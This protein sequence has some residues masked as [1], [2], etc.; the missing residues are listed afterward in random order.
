VFGVL[1]AGLALVLATVLSRAPGQFEL[2]KQFSDP[3]LNQHT[4]IAAFDRLNVHDVFVFPRVVQ[5]VE[6]IDDPE[7]ARHALDRLARL[8]AEDPGS[9]AA[10]RES[11]VRDQF[12]RLL[13][14]L[15]RHE[16][17]NVRNAAFDFYSRFAPP[18]AVV[19][20]I[21]S[22]ARPIGKRTATAM[23]RYLDGLVLAEVDDQTL[24]KLLRNLAALVRAEEEPAL[25]EACAAKLDTLPPE[26][27]LDCLMRAF[28]P[29]AV[30]SAARDVL[31]PYLDRTTPERARA[32]GRYVEGRVVQ[33]VSRSEEGIDTTFELEF[34]IQALG[35]IGTLSGTDYD[36]GLDAIAFLLEHRDSLCDTDLLDTVMDA[37]ALLNHDKRVS[38]NPVREILRDERAT[39]PNRVAA[40]DA[41]GRLKDVQ[42]LADLKRLAMD[43]GVFFNLRLR[44]V[45][46]LGEL[47]GAL[48]QNGADAAGLG[49]ILTVLDDILGHHE[50]QPTDVV[51]EAVM[52]FGNLADAT[53]APRLFPLLLDRR[54]NSDATV[55]VLRLLTRQPEKADDVVRA[56]LPW[57][58]GLDERP[59]VAETPDRAIVGFCHYLKSTEACQRAAKAVASAL[60]RAQAELENRPERE[61][62]ARLLADF[63]LAKD[64]PVIEPAADKPARI[65]QLEQWQRWWEQ[66][67]DQF[68]L[69]A[70]QLVRAAS[71]P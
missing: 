55:A 42:S 62:A 35:Q 12:T 4:R 46:S 33:L 10:A 15:L 37:F 22:Q 65:A 26:R 36:R 17:E 27:L 45:R 23:A 24:P 9:G 68:H 69:K 52:S 32:L 71:D 47:A 49:E 57:Q 40:A 7:V 34:L 13:A 28:E 64:A 39:W 3:A 48:A 43:P 6:D 18:D 61:Y 70:G 38:L 19:E 2:L 56:F 67:A 14:A 59:Q 51:R 20:T 63:L 50:D 66:A 11:S 58:T 29:S 21:R 5:A 30:K 54:Y 25:A 8:A 44:A 1:V 41:V 53:A 16:S 60:A 31:T